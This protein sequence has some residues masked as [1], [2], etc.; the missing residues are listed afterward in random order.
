MAD[1]YSR[2]VRF[3]SEYPWAM[4]PSALD[5][6][7]EVIELRIEG[8]VLTEDEIRQRIGAQAPA[9]RARTQGT[10]AVLPL[11]G[12]MAHRMSM[13]TEISGGTSTEAFGLAFRRLIEDPSVSAV[14]FDVDS[15][16]G[17]VFGM[18]ELGNE[19]FRARG[20]KPII[21]VANATMASAAYFVASQADEI[22][23][24]PSGMV[25]SIGTLAVHVDRTK[26]ASD[27]GVKVTFIT[28]GGLKAREGNDL[29]P[30]D[31]EVRASMQRKVDAYYDA[32]VRA[33]ARGRGIKAD[34]IRNGI[35]DGRVLTATDAK[36]AGMVDGIATLDSVIA[37]LAGGAKSVA[38]GA[39]AALPETP[40]FTDAEAVSRTMVID[41][42]RRQLAE[43]GA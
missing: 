41:D 5:A 32:F 31:D 16:G 33:V 6:L 34:A 7:M 11:F 12:V 13:M 20:L 35:G 36:A 18:E 15:P 10:V 25:G 39:R 3:I 21:A 19:I 29:V 28:S 38:G 17:S 40:E 30:L 43:R 26:Q 9:P 4:L 42:F 24:T 22:L 2:I 1:K 23:V 27:A 14:V 37:R 8:R